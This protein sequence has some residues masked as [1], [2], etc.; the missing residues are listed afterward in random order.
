M[1]VQMVPAVKMVLEARNRIVAKHHFPLAVVYFHVFRDLGKFLSE[2]A[3][4]GSVMV[5]LDQKLLT[6]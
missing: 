1:T 2:R 4:V 3:V 6:I 5:A